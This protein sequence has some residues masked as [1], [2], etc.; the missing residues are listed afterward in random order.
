MARGGTLESVRY[1]GYGP[2]GA[3]VLADCLT[4]DRE[5]TAAELRRAFAR[6]G[7]HLGASGAV[8]YLFNEV[9]AL[10]FAAAAGTADR[11]AQTALEAGAEDVITHADGRLEVLTAPAELEAVQRALRAA[12]F[13]PTSAMRTFRSSIQVT[14]SGAPAELLANLLGALGALEEVQSVYSN[15]TV[16]DALLARLPA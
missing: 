2:G 15:A 12:D 9:G 3:A 14:L 7:G 11:L 1:E 5:R 16:P 6:Y 8:G 4:G 13:I 10:V